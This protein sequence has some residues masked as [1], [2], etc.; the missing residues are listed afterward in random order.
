[1]NLINLTGEIFEADH[2]SVGENYNLWKE[3]PKFHVV[4]FDI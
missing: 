2:L 4:R 3:L 1:M